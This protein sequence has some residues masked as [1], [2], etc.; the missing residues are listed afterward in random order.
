MNWN[1]EICIACTQGKTFNE[2]SKT[3]ECPYP[4]RWNGFVCKRVSECTGGK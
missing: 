1:G 2:S 4:L 3:C